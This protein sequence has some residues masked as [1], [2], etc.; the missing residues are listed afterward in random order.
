[1]Q[2]SFVTPSTSALTRG[3]AGQGEGSVSCTH[4]LDQHLGASL[5]HEEGAQGGMGENRLGRQREVPADREGD[6][7]EVVGD[8]HW[9]QGEVVAD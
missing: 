9:G 7:W 5:G 4:R 3:L 2:P 6:Y 8:G 1:M